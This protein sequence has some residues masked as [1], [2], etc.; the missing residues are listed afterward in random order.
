MMGQ[1]SLIEIKLGSA[2]F[3]MVLC[4]K[5]VWDEI[6]VERPNSFPLHW[7]CIRCIL[8]RTLASYG[9]FVEWDQ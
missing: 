9:K 6:M 4:F 3:S 5:V 1:P 7:P 8:G 2:I